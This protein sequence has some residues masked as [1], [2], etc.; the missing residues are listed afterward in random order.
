MYT[1]VYKHP[2]GKAI[3]FYNDG[4]EIAKKMYQALWTMTDA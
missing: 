4:S 3:L 2:Q 1:S